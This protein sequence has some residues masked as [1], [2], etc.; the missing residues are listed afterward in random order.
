MKGELGRCGL[1]IRRSR[2]ENVGLG[3]CFLVTEGART[4]VYL[5]LLGKDIG[6]LEEVVPLDRVKLL[7][8]LEEGDTRILV[9][10]TIAS[11]MISR[12]DSKFYTTHTRK[13]SIRLLRGDD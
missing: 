7:E 6:V 11:R 1:K 2:R 5:R 9:F 10:L 8:V 13:Q 12:R 3:L 4:V